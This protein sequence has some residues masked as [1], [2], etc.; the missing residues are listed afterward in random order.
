MVSEDAVVK[1]QHNAT[2]IYNKN[3]DMLPPAHAAAN[4]HQK[5]HS[6]SSLFLFRG[7]LRH[8]FG[9]EPKTVIDITSYNTLSFFS[10]LSFFYIY[11]D[12]LPFLSF[13]F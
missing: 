10:R 13:I 8:H 4:S 5:R 11:I 6:S 7:L 1:R 9:S 2:T 12:D 3:D